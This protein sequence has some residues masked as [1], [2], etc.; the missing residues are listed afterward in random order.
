MVGVIAGW[1]NFTTV[2]CATKQCGELFNGL[3]LHVRHYTLNNI[4]TNQ[5]AFSR[6]HIMDLNWSHQA[7]G[8]LA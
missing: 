8:I 1:L 5:T 2:T 6:E 4:T 7:T 3:C